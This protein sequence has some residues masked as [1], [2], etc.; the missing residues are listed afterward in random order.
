MTPSTH[1]GTAIANSTVGNNAVHNRAVVFSPP[2]FDSMAHEAAPYVGPNSVVAIQSPI[3]ADFSFPTMNLNIGQANPTTGSPLAFNATVSGGSPP[4]AF[5]WNFTDGSFGTGPSLS[6]VFSLAG[7]YNVTLTV[8]DSTASSLIVSHL[9]S[10]V[11]ASTVDFSYPVASVNSPVAFNGTQGFYYYYWDFG[12]GGSYSNYGSSNGAFATHSYSR[13]GT[14]FVVLTAYNSTIGG[15]YSTAS[16]V[17]VVGSGVVAADFVYPTISVVVGAVYPSSGSPIVFNATA[18]GGTS[19]YTFTWDFGDGLTST[20]RTVTHIFFAAGTF[21]VVLTVTDASSAHAVASRF[22]LV[23]SVPRIDFVSYPTITAGSPTVFNATT[24]GFASYYWDFG[25]GT[26][27]YPSSL[28]S[29]TYSRSGTYF[30]VLSGYNASSYTGFYPTASHAIVVG[31]SVVAVDFSFPTSNIAIGP[32]TASTGSPVAFNATATGGTSPYTFTWNFGD[33][34]TATGR[35]ATHVFFTAGAYTVVLTT[36]DAG[37]I[38]ATA[39]HYVIVA[40]TFQVDFSLQPVSAGSPTAFNATLGLYLYYWD[41][42]DGGTYFNYGSSNGAFATHTYSRSGSYFVTLTTYNQSS[43]QAT[44]S[45]I[46]TVVSSA[47]TADFV[48]PNNNIAVGAANPTTGSPVAFNVTSVQ[49]GTPPYTFAWNFG[50]GSL[51]PGS[52]PTHTFTSPGSYIVVLTTT[53]SS[54]VKATASRFVLVQSA[55]RLDFMSYRTITAGSPTVFNATLGFTHYY[56][57]FGDGIAYYGGVAYGGSSLASHTYSRSGT[58]FVVLSGY[59]ASSY[60][61]FYSTA[62]HVLTVALVLWQQTLS[63]LLPM[64][65]WALCIRVLVVLW[66]SMLR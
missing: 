18:T 1:A 2:L 65:L 5:D 37:G 46:L 43:I 33:G 23:R 25:D 20:G 14:F 4:Y 24:P 56:W 8:H 66:F 45:H 40:S 55:P 44:A 17:L 21:I 61:G 29:H 42:G 32:V 39:S 11:L 26:Y 16:H 15:G 28:A 19:P 35:T 38:V 10:V 36:I 50:D 30:V 3:S 62:S 41:F 27:S 49:G 59:N 9:V 34:S 64:L 58:Y 54:N 63:I 48:Y 31:S 22:V 53:D 12:D 13:S 6:H 60:N 7:T 47:V 57:D 51:A 52:S